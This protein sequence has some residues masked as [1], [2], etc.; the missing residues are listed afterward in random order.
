MR[1]RRAMTF[2]FKHPNKYK[3][4]YVPI[5]ECKVGKKYRFE[6]HFH[7]VIDYDYNYSYMTGTCVTNHIYKDRDKVFD[8]YEHLIEI[9]LHYPRPELQGEYDNKLMFYFPHDEEMYDDVKV[10]DYE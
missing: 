2:T 4:K 10:V 8:Q 3:T 9:K 6:K 5:R 1:E 7:T